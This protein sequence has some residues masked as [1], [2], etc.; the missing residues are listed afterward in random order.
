MTWHATMYIYDCINWHIHV[1]VA[2]VIGG[3]SHI[4]ILLSSSSTIY[5]HISSSVNDRR[6]EQRT[7]RL[8]PKPGILKWQPAGQI[9]PA[10]PL[11]VAHG[12]ALIKGNYI[13]LMHTSCACQ[14]T[15]LFGQIIHPF[16]SRFSMKPTP[17]DPFL[18]NLNIKVK[19][20]ACFACI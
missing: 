12:Q 11:E 20:L 2:D 1:V 10:V 9:Q 5:D 15:P 19:I 4:I 17:N 6:P 8:F 14:M 7:F 3:C 16:Y 13:G 18:E